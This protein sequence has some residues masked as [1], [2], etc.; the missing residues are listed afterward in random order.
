M[1]TSLLFLVIGT[2]IS[3]DDDFIELTEQFNSKFLIG[4]A[5]GLT[6]DF[7]YQTVASTS[8]DMTE[9]DY[10]EEIEIDMIFFSANLTSFFTLFSSVSTDLAF[11]TIESFTAVSAPLVTILLTG[12]DNSLNESYNGSLAAWLWPFFTIL[13]I[14]TI[15]FRCIS[16][17]I[18]ITSNGLAGHILVSL[19]ILGTV[20]L[21]EFS[22]FWYLHFLVLFLISLT[23]SVQI[24]EFL[25]TCIQS[26]VWVILSINYVS[27]LS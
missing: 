20:I 27:I 24:M 25:V 21:L 1:T 5:G 2:I 4:F 19:L 17:S 9:E 7:A 11:N 13:E 18:R 15:I 16:L 6:D 23:V 10:N 22:V 26:Y 12:L 8:L 3:I 14:L